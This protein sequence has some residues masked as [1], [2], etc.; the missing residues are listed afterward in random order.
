MNKQ[1]LDA[2][3]YSLHAIQDGASLEAV[4]ARYPEIARELRP[5]LEAAQK[6]RQLSGPMPSE[7]TISRTRALLLQR[8]GQMRKPAR[9]SVIPLFQRLAFSL[10]LASVLLLSG[11]GLVKASS[12]TLPGDNLYPVKRTWEDVRLMLVFAPGH[13]DVLES[14][15][16]Q[17][18]LD[19][20]SQVLHE[21]R[22]V[23]I[24]FTGLITSTTDGQIVVSG[25][26]VAITLQTQ[27][28][29]VQAVNGA[30]VI[31][32][33]KTDSLGQVTAMTVQVLPSGSFVPV[34]EAAQSEHQGSN[35]NS[36][37]TTFH[38][39]GTV[40]AMNNS[41]L[42]IGDRIVY[43]DASLTAGITVGNQVEVKGYF[44]SDG[45]FI[46]TE[47]E[48]EEGDTTSESSGKS[49]ESEIQQPD[50]T[51]QEDHSGEDHSNEDHPEVE[52]PESEH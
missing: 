49:P 27:F 11:T 5:L 1:V 24:S 52:T 38:L 2:L 22:L 48:L 41:T 19:E 51:K 40:K 45:R 17:E 8:A 16:E 13:R 42:T 9:I 32:T 37:S 29:G 18:R 35:G 10:V 33:G 6:A 36:Q 7:A 15:Y 26:P 47:L 30:A 46:A 28:S 3:D 12:S 39:E 44:T 43:L 23:P 31:V 4:L 50:A 21:G 25:V 34:A 20:V 14:E